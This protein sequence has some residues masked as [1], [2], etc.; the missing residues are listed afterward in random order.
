MYRIM[1]KN[2]YD[3]ITILDFDS[4]D[5]MRVALCVLIESIGGIENFEKMEFKIAKIKKINPEYKF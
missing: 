3:D 5:S 4:S 1:F 2:Q